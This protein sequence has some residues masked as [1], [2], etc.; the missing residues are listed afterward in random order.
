M[1][2]SKSSPPPRKRIFI[3]GGS[4]CIGHYI[5]E[6]LIDT[7]PHELF[8]L[9]R[10]PAKVQF[11]VEAREGVHLIHGDM[12]DIEHQG[13]LLKTI[14]IA[15]LTANAWGGTS[16]VF[17]VNIAKTIRLINLLDPKRCQQVLYFST[18]SILDHQ[19]KLLEEAKQIGTDYIRS[20]YD[21]HSRLGRLELAPKIT[22][23]FPTLVFGGS[24]TKPYSHISG[25]L[26]EVTKWIGLARFF[27]ADASFHYLHGRDIATVVRYL[28]DNPLP[29][30]V[31]NQLDDIYLKQL[32][33]GNPPL[34]VNEALEEV[35][36]YFGK[37]IY[38]QIPLS[39]WLANFFINVFGIQVAAWDRFCMKYR[40]F[41]YKNP[42]NPA[43]FG[44][45]VFCP[46]LAD[47]LLAT[48][49]RGKVGS[50]K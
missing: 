14:D 27:K 31:V 34:T 43:T 37:K 32:V 45:P 20:K 29:Y 3:T 36:A 23:L 7:S 47:I 46:T 13:E 26:A 48:G 33:L 18:A 10:N 42:V 11:D 40:H 49:I 8:F 4:G 50:G 41:T 12:H 1:V 21:C 35:C 9:V 22:I 19:N 15:I 39:L 17:D 38:F 16:E 2:Q 24:S 44:L 5:A 30:D 25:G 6:T 28:V